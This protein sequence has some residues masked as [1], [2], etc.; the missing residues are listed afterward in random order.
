M[1]I[2]V[3]KL[4]DITP[5]VF[6]VNQD[7]GVAL[8]RQIGV[9]QDNNGAYFFTVWQLNRRSKMWS[10]TEAINENYIPLLEE[11]YK[12]KSYYTKPR[13]EELDKLIKDKLTKLPLHLVTLV[14][15]GSHRFDHCLNNAENRILYRSFSQHAGSASLYYLVVRANKENLAKFLVGTLDS[16]QY[17]L[18]A[19][20]LD[21]G[22]RF[23]S[24]AYPSDIVAEV[25]EVLNRERKEVCC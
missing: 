13:L 6:W 17:Y 15:S 16:S 7:K 3:C 21:E 12:S 22:L 4:S 5:G 11:A 25:N 23:S 10:T 20:L 24:T 9:D 1:S 2:S 14:V 19:V 8:S 18:G